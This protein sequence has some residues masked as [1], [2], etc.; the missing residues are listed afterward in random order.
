MSEQLFKLTPSA[1]LQCYFLTPSAVAAMSQASET[2]FIVSGKWRQQ[3]DWAVV[4][5]NR[6]N[7][8]EHPALRNLPDADL[9]GL[10]L[11]YDEQ[12]TGCIPIESDL[13][14]VVAWDQ[15]RLW[16]P[17]SDGN[18]TVYYVNLKDHSTP[19]SGSH[20]S[21]SAT[22][23][24]SASPGS[25][26]RAGLAFL[27][28]HHYY[29]ALP[30]DQLSDI[31]AGIAADIQQLSAVCTAT[32]SEASITVTW[33]PNGTA[34][35]NLLG[36][37]GN[38]I[39]MY[40]FA[41][42]AALV[43][44]QPFAAFSGGAFPTQYQIAL[45]FANLKGK[46]DADSDP[47]QPVPTSNVRKLRWTWA[48]DQ[49]PAT[50]EQ[51]EFQVAISNWNVTGGS[52]EYSVAGPGS[53]RIEDSDSEVSYTGS[54]T[55]QTGNY[56]GSKIHSTSAVGD[57][58][59]ITYSETAEHQLFLGTRL[60]ASGANVTVSIDGQSPAQQLSL[61]L[62]G[63]D[64]LIRAPLGTY[65]PG[66]HTMSLTHAGPNLNEIYF[67]FLEIAYP[68]TDL[69]SFESQT[70]LSLATDWDTYHS[71]SLPAERTAWLINKLGFYG[72][73]NHY[74]GALWFYELVRTGTQYASL[75]VTLNPISGYSGSPTV[76]L[77]FAAPGTPDSPTLVSH[78]VLV[79]DTP[80]NVAEALAALINTGT[81]LLWAS[82]SSNNLT[83]TARA[84]GILGNG[85]TVGLDPSSNG[86]TLDPAS[87][88]LSGGIDGSPYD[89]DT[90]DP[91]NST[92]I[93]AAD[94]WRT[95]FTALP[96]LNR[97][98]RDWHLAYFTA[99]KGYGMDAVASFS[100]ELLNG[101]PSTEAG[102]AQQYPDGTPVVLNTPAIQTNFSPTTLA[103]WQQVYLDMAAIQANA[104]MTPYLQFGEVQWWYFQKQVW[105][106]ATG[107][108]IDIGMPFYDS[109]TEQQFQAKYGVAMQII[110]N[111]A[112]DPNEY[113]NETAFLPTL[114]G[115]HTEAIRSALQTQF[116]GCRYEVL[117]PTDTND[118]PLNQLVNFPA[119]DWT[120]ANLTCL[121]TESFIFTGSYNLDLS[122]YSMGVSVTKGF[123]NQ[124]RSHL[125]GISDAWTSWMKEADI[126]QS[127]GLE[128][129][130]LFALDQF[131]LV[132][133][134]APP[135]VKLARSHKQG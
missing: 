133:Y 102:I 16:V 116:P 62:N 1:D 114:I 45:D 69:P 82:A 70:Q 17:G 126:A 100:T 3:F 21:A 43:W 20:V 47:N 122:T 105:D 26:K 83:F 27:E 9:S 32:S 57:T 23:T 22:M 51:I 103:F 5:W 93:A 95:D 42:D 48:A 72:R 41:E 30:G 85:I 91:L 78:L 4:E 49:Q 80:A 19:I 38:R 112:V 35:P 84:M 59:T 118:T 15:L 128:S 88:I 89:L 108:N 63:E 54:W 101:D 58:C 135:F 7:V 104:G 132:G 75:T 96:R 40:G 76:V 44:Q 79:D 55:L 33:N 130:V 127:Q 113:P 31:A 77:A 11:T 14:P 117:Y 120:S 134:S 60:F 6:D 94:Y 73:V 67:D 125:V 123:S 68:S 74:T 115:S 8:F 13:Y 64:V 53:R 39:T 109:Y 92:L 121:K 12:R 61:F 129:V 90:T 28:E 56:S 66:T 110:L 131:C 52:R 46:T 29:T 34:Y 71:Q 119:A 97:A 124:Q 18:E 99:L 86:Y 24:L 87:G 50:F 111:N 10:T 65:G 36:A 81:N 106:A 98:A 107:S 25:G 2:G 37:N